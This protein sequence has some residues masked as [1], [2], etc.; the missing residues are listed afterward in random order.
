MEEIQQ[1]VERAVVWALRTDRLVR[2][3][4][5]NP[6]VIRHSKRAHRERVALERLQMHAILAGPHP[7]GVIRRTRVHPPIGPDRNRADRGRVPRKPL[8]FDCARLEGEPPGLLRRAHKTKRQSV[9]RATKTLSYR[10]MASIHKVEVEMTA[11]SD[12]RMWRGPCI[13]PTEPS[14]Q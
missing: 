5:V 11:R 12:R 14:L 8:W 13:C 4:R 2:G 6:A 10:T 3:S 1:H 9:S 7:R